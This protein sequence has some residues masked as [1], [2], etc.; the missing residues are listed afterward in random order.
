MLR[1]CRHSEIVLAE[2]S[3]L[4]PNPVILPSFV[5]A[6]AERQ[7]LPRPIRVELLFFAIVQAAPQAQR[8][9]DEE[10]HKGSSPRHRAAPPHCGIFLN[11]YCWGRGSLPRTIYCSATWKADRCAPAPSH[12]IGA[13]LPSASICPRSR[14]MGCGT[15][16]PRN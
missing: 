15:P 5:I 13:M 12:P 1:I 14:F 2:Q 6:P 8:V 4:Q 11:S 10:E 7:E 16:M 3:V 9:N